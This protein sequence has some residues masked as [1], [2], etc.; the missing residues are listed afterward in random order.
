VSQFLSLS[1][2]LFAGFLPF[3]VESTERYFSF[4]LIYE[5]QQAAGRQ[6]HHFFIDPISEAVLYLPDD[7]MMEAVIVYPDGQYS[8]F[9]TDEGGKKVAIH[10]V[11]TL[12]QV[13]SKASIL[14]QRI[15]ASNVDI[16]QFPDFPI[17][18]GVTYLPQYASGDTLMTTR[19]LPVNARCLAIFTFLPGDAKCSLPLI[20]N[21][22]LKEDEVLLKINSS[23]QMI[24]F[25]HD[26]Y[27]FN[28]KNYQP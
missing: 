24:W 19:S 8:I 14:Y 25:G 11:V 12:P 5:Q 18:D 23:C 6:E 28:P 1:A 7:D 27:Y 17:S 15:P 26:Q 2:A 20:Y 4:L 9:G 21:G 22:I 16:P 13:P 10:G 3:T